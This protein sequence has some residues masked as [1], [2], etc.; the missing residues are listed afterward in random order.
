VD[1]N[2]YEAGSETLSTRFLFGADARVNH[3]RRRGADL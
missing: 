2:C 3:N 1:G